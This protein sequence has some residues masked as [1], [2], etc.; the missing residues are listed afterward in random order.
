M[1]TQP[2]GSVT[3]CGISP[4]FPGLSLTLGQVGHVLLTR[5]PLGSSRAS[6]GALVRLA[7][8]KH[9]AS[10]RPE[11]GSNS[12]LRISLMNSSMNRTRPVLCT[13]R[14][15]RNLRCYDLPT[16][17]S[18]ATRRSA[19]RSGPLNTLN[20]SVFNQ[21]WARP[22]GVPSTDGELLF[23]Q[24]AALGIPSAVRCEPQF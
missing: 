16:R 4:G 21:L 22:R 7:C 13:D 8:V 24:N 3:S 23:E 17:R 11:P 2:C 12:P 14:F 15:V 20:T 9:A 19:C 1:I 10:V 18:D 6:S 5:S